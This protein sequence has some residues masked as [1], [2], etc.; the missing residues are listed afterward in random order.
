M[1]VNKLSNAQ[2]DFLQAANSQN[3]VN[4]FIQNEKLNFGGCSDLVAYIG[5]DGLMEFDVNLSYIKDVEQDIDLIIL[6]C[7]SQE[8][9]QAEILKTGQPI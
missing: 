2:K 8:F 6:A 9:F 1:M 5:H 7:Y 4:I 3:E